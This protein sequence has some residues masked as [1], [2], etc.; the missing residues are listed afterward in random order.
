[1]TLIG[2]RQETTEGE[3]RLNF[4]RSFLVSY[5]NYYLSKIIRIL[6]YLLKP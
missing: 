6:F 4:I 5:G 2:I 3:H 1:M